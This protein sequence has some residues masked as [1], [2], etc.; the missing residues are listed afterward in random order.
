MIEAFRSGSWKLPNYFD[1][2]GGF[3][4]VSTGCQDADQSEKARSDVQDVDSTTT[5]TWRTAEMRPG[6]QNNGTIFKE[7]Q[8]LRENAHM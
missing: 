4:C 6:A 8:T 3:A 7:R 5:S 2:S 1:L